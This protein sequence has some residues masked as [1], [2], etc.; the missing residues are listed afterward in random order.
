MPLLEHVEELRWRALRSILA[1]LVGTVVG[2]II[3]ERMDVIGLL[4]RPIA[5]LL[6]NGRLNFTSPTEPF[7]VT[8]KC[9]FILGLLLASPYVG[10]EIW[11]FFAPALDRRERRLIVPSLS[12]GIVL[13]LLG[14]FS[15][16][17]WVLPRSLAVLLSF[18]RQAFEPIITAEKYFSFATQIIVAFG[19][20]TELPLV[21]VILAALGLV[22]PRFLAKN[23]RYAI[24]LSAGAA[25][26]LAPPDAISMVLMMVPLWLLYEVSIVC[27]W[28][29]TK[30]R[31]LRMA[32]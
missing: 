8:L 29:V 23:R 2:W 11:G 22:T 30:R 14:A 15:A 32:R 6:P 7:F 9:A 18:Q 20:I 16:Y 19:V 4:I 17:S 1:A 21:M 31:G 27:A 25:A 26:L 5:P 13:F 24:G 28:I 12:A 3:V 10:F